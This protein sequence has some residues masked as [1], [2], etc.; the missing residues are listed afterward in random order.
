MGIAEGVGHL[1]SE[2]IIHGNLKSKNVL[3]DRN[4]RPYV[5]DFGLH[6]VLNPTAGQ[7]MLEASASGGYRA[8]EM[9]KMKDASKES[10]VYSLGVIFLELLSGKL[11][12]ECHLPSAINLDG[13]L[14]NREEEGVFRSY[15]QLGMACCSSSPRLRPSIDQ[16]LE[17]L[18]EIGN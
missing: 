15:F 9:I 7:Q 13:S 16:V 11:S 17:K 12:E 5:S 14:Y 1:H 2:H 4:N 18:Q 10:D 8:P 3:L 6:L